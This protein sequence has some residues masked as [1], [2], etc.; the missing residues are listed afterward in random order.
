MKT[1]NIGAGG[2]WRAPVV[3]LTVQVISIHP[4]AISSA[5]NT[6]Q[7]DQVFAHEE[8]LA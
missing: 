1:L 8:H 6:E 5:S 3:I 2:A 7:N 4:G